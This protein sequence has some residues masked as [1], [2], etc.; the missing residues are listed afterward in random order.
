MGLR[1]NIRTLLN[2]RYKDI[3]NILK[4]ISKRKKLTQKKIYCS[5]FESGC[6]NISLAVEEKFKIKLKS[7]AYDKLTS[8]ESLAKYLKKVKN[9]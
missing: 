1:K 2:E 8:I 6:D 7:D 4:K 5:R 3:T 9:K